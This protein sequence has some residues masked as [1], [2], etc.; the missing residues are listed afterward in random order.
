MKIKIFVLG[1]L[2]LCLSAI[3]ANAW[4]VSGVVSCPNGNSASN[5]V[6]F[7]T[8]VGSTTT[9]ANGAYLLS[10]PTAAATYTI[11]VDP[12]SL[13]PGATVSGCTTFSVDFNNQFTTVN[14]TLG[15]SFCEGPPATGACWLTGGGTIGKTRHG[16]VYSF[17]GVVNPGCNPTAA[18]GGNWNVIDHVNHLHFQGLNISVIG[19]SGTSDKSPPVKVNIIDFQGTGTL[20]GI[21]GNPL[22][23][24]SVCFIARAEDHGEPGK[25]KDRLYLD[26][27]DCTTGASLLLISADPAHPTDVAPVTISTGNLQI[28]TSGCD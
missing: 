6:V 9:S 19:C 17:G 5:I 11:C 23:K 1:L 25:G 7:I 2:A 13:P 28:H 27:T 22:S 18:G 26:V 14:F 24:R 12:S 16:P 3:T 10:L 21:G 4:N 8:G 15:G 20:V